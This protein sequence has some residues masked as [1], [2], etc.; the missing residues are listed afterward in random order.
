MIFITYRFIQVFAWELDKHGPLL[1]LFPGVGPGTHEDIGE[2]QLGK[3]NLESKHQKRVPYKSNG[4]SL[5]QVGWM[6]RLHWKKFYS[7][8]FHN[9]SPFTLFVETKVMTSL[10]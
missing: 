7:L 2:P 10:K 3:V 5:E 9:A 1:P 8:T 6:Y 4:C